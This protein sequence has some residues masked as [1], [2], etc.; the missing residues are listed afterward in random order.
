MRRWHSGDR[1]IIMRDPPHALGGDL[2]EHCCQGYAPPV[3]AI[4]GM[5]TGL[6]RDEPRQMIER[7]GELAAPAQREAEVAQRRIERVGVLLGD[8]EK[9]EPLALCKA[10]APADDE[11]SVVVTTEIDAEL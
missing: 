3:A 7:Q 10:A 6:Q 11:A 2:A 5:Q 1:Q 9:V 8:F 4:G